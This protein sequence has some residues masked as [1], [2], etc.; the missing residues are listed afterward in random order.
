MT[1]TLLGMTSDGLVGG[2]EA[3]RAHADGLHVPHLAGRELDAVADPEG[4][5][6]HQ[7]EAREHVGQ[8]VL[9]GQ[10][11]GQGAHA[12]GHHQGLHVD[13]EVLRGS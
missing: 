5:V 3:R 9:G 1:S 12:Q 11:H 13:A 8:G 10:A 2:P 4:P 6:Q 7:G